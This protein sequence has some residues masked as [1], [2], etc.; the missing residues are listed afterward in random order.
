[1]IDDI[2]KNIDFSNMFEP[3]FDILEDCKVKKFR[4]KFRRRKNVYTK[5][6]ICYNPC[7]DFLIEN[8]LFNLKFLRKNFNRK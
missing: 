8:M 1:M 5:Y 3:I 7:R 6:L 4:R 2:L